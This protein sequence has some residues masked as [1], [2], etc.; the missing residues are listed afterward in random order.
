MKVSREILW[1]WALLVFKPANIRLW[2]LS[3]N[4]DDIVDF[5]TALKNHEITAVTEKEYQRVD[6]VTFDDA[7]KV[8]DRCQEL[9]IKVYCY[10]SEGYPAQLKRIPNPPAVLFCRGNLDFINDKC[11]IAVVGARNPSEYS[12]EITRK[13]GK[14]MIE[15]KMLLA[16]GFAEGI[17]RL[18]NEVSIECG[19]FPIAVSAVSLDVDYPK[20][21]G[22]IKEKICD[23]GVVISE[24][25]PGS[26][27][28]PNAFVN[29]NRILIGISRAV[30]FI[31]ANKYSH[32]L[33]NANHAISQGKSLFVVPPHDI[34]DKR[35]F[36][37]RD[38]IRNECQ[39]VFGAADIAFWL[40]K[41][42]GD[43]F[44][45]TKSLGDFTLPAQDSPFYYEDD[46]RPRKKKSKRSK[47]KKK[48]K[49]E[50]QAEMQ[51]KS[52]DYSSL[53]ECEAEICRLL[54]EKNML[55]DEISAMTGMDISET[56]ATLT[57]LEIEGLVK[58]LP[59]KLF[60]I[61]FT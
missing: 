43:D 59:G 21:S 56:L 22:E 7:Q 48:V 40:S 47:T 37:Q 25:Y 13:F 2:K 12:I 14:E 50:E 28:L 61:Y 54:E 38:L 24:H 36:G 31:E 55:A 51:K 27:R 34:Y 46:E 41:E 18:T 30:L 11:I 45:L 52:V 29:R 3:D 23:S 33:D 32:G 8:L 9:N 57:E 35:Y 58:S 10:E 44:I 4:Y 6:E 1:L 26:E 39:C 20:D 15:R 42:C 53:T 17:D 49:V 19:S 5:T 60:G 16:S